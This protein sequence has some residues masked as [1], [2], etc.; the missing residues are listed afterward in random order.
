MKKILTII[1]GLSLGVSTFAQIDPTTGEGVVHVWNRNDYHDLDL[2][3][4]LFTMNPTTCLPSYQAMGP[5]HP[6]LPGQIIKYAKYTDSDTASGHPLPID[7]WYSNGSY[8]LPSQIPQNIADGQRWTY[9]KFE[10]REP[11]NPGQ[12]IPGMGGSVSI[13]QIC[14]NIPES[15]VGSGTTSGGTNYDFVAKAYIIGGDLWFDVY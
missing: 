9:M 15:L 3:F 6:L 11:S 7:G 8:F 12:F 14:T 13:N 5:D 1:F 10:L 2:Y 4:T